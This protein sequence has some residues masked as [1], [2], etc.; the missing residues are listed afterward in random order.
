MYWRYR[1][2]RALG[3]L[4][5]L[6]AAG[7]TLG[8]MPPFVSTSALVVDGDRVLVVVDPVR[9]EPTLPGGHLK[10][11]EKP[12]A[13]V[14]REVQEET[15][16]VIHPGKLVGVFSGREWA[17][18][19]GVVRIVFAATVAGGSLSSSPEGEAAWIPLDELLS[20][21]TRDAPIVQGWLER[22][23]PWSA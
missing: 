15:G 22:G 6:L 7:L 17:G 13:A 16:Y 8:R 14:I 5:T 4:V 3:R 1:V 19:R 18:E 23:D 11:A 21:S 2:L 20:S 9:G 10:W 12:L